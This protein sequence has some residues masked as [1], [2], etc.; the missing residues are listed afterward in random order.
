MHI[1]AALLRLKFPA[2]GIFF[3]YNEESQPHSTGE[4][5]LLS[6]AQHS[7]YQGCLDTGNSSA[8]SKSSISNT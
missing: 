6:I 3:G 4:G 7:E 5:L 1:L 8:K 2:G